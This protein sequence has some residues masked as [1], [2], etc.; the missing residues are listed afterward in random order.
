M[1]RYMIRLTLVFLALFAVS[2]ARPAHA[3]EAET[4]QYGSIK[5]RRVN[6]RAGPGFQ[7]P[8]RWIFQRRDMPVL[9]QRELDNWYLIRD[10]QGEE[11]WIHRAAISRQRTVIVVGVMRA[12][13]RTP[14][15]DAPL[16]ARV[17][18]GVVGRLDE[19]EGGWCRADFDGFRGWIPRDQIWGISPQD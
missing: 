14:A 19:C 13:R 9:L 10:W 7:Y 4:A 16:V 18:G 15:P 1:T 8:I 3:Q 17:Q 6:V 11:G 5:W 12:V 2:P